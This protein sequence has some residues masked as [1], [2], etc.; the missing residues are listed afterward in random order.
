MDSK[1]PPESKPPSKVS[2]LCIMY[3]YNM[4]KPSDENPFSKV[5]P[6][7]YYPDYTVGG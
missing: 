6:R 3:S 2:P 7:A 4:D 5:S 1:P